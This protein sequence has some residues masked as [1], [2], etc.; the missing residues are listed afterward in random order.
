MH[1]HSVAVKYENVLQGGHIAPPAAR[2]V[3]CVHITAT[4]AGRVTYGT[5]IQNI[6]AGRQAA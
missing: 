3:T 1:D 4:Q 5:E 2:R 6:T